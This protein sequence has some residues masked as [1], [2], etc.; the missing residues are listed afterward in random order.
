[1]LEKLL[2]SHKV[3]LT[4]L[5]FTISFGLYSYQ[6]L[7]REA[8][9]DISF[10]IIY[11]SIVHQGI[12]PEDS[13]RLLIKPLEKELKNIE[14]VKKMSSTSYLGGG[15][16][17]LEFDAGFQSEKALNDVRVKVDFVKSKLPQETKEPIV[18]EVN[19]SR[20]PVLAIAVSGKIEKRALLEVSKEL[21][22]KIEEL[23]QILE[24]KI[25]GENERQIEINVDPKT[26]KAY[27]LTAKEVIVSIIFSPVR[28]ETSNIIAFSPLFLAYPK[29][30]L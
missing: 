20:F 14:G 22:S 21:K 4:I 25:I 11:V 17:V 13:E 30:S 28:L 26:V 1:M 9:P 5:F 3:L 27:G 19:L 2:N 29:I 8:D 10:P 16:L 18:S 15:N 7:P 24:V 12:S 6:S 23:S